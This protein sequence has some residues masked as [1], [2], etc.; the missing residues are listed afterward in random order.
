MSCLKHLPP[1]GQSWSGNVGRGRMCWACFPKGR[2]TNKEKGSRG[3]K[4]ERGGIGR[5]G[6][7]QEKKREVGIEKS[8]GEEKKN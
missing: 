7:G 1:L 3:I 2:E 5:K 8:K 4:K 6:W